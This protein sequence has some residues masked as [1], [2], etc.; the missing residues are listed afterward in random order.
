M[1]DKITVDYYGSPTPINQLAAIAVAEARILTIT[2]WDTSVMRG[3]EKAILESDLGIN[4][5]NDG[6]VMR[7]VFPAPTEERRRQLT[8]DVAKLGEESKVATRNIRRDAIDKFKAMKKASE[9]T[10]DDQKELETEIQKLTDRFGKEIDKLCE[11]KN[12]EIM[13]I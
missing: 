4:P 5:T 13:E 3:I 8:K 7:L 11:A 9:I 10:E 1:L 6:R 12:K 2:P